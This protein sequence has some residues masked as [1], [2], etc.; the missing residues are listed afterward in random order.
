MYDRKENFETITSIW[1][2][3]RCLHRYDKGKDLHLLIVNDGSLFEGKFQSLRGFTCP[4]STGASS[5]KMIKAKGLS[6]KPREDSQCRCRH[7]VVQLA[8]FP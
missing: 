1:N 6:E 5:A 3:V 4:Y 7:D 8:T 2:I